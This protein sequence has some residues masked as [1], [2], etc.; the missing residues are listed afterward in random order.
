MAG[1]PACWGG[2]CGAALL[3]GGGGGMFCNESFLEA[4]VAFVFGRG[5]IGGGEVVG[6]GI[7]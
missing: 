5:G 3:G 1:G 2:S 6:G 7:T 4:W